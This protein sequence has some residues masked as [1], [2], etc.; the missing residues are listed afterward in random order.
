MKTA[1]YQLPIFIK[2]IGM[3][4]TTHK[5]KRKF[6][7][8]IYRCHC[9]KEFETNMNSVASG[10]TKS[11]GCARGEN[12]NLSGTH[13]YMVW[14]DMIRRTSNENYKQYVEYGGRGITV[15]DRWKD[16]KNFC[17]DM[18]DEY[19]DGLSIDRINN[20]LGYF[21]ENCRW[22]TQ[23]VQSQNTRLINSR[24]TSGYR[25]IHYKID[26][27]KWY[28]KIMVNSKTKHL[29]VFNTAIDA[30]KAY[31]RYVIDNGLEHT[32]NNV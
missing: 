11:C 1:S 10:N 18:A 17:I 8:A 12:H 20:D 31:D 28:A 15:C 9:G 7:F 21:K 23:N 24:N 16:V 5:S 3:K 29:G 27:K 2:D 26:R 19:R 32:I 6:R 30:A 4:Y 25:G 14:K 22:T 13:M